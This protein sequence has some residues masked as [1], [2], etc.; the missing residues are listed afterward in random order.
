MTTELEL[1]GSHVYRKDG[2]TFVFL[3][4]DEM[5]ELKSRADAY[6][7]FAREKCATCFIDSKEVNDDGDK[8]S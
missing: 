7:R 1:E 6:E 5:D 3:D 4:A 8:N 2:R